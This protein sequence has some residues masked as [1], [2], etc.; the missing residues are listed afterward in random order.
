MPTSLFS[1]M[2]RG[3]NG[4]GTASLEDQRALQLALELSML[5]LEGTPGCPGTGTG[6]GTGTTNDPDPLQTTPAGVFE[7]ARSKKSQNMTECVPVPSS[8]HVAEIVGRQGCKIKALR[9]KTNT[10]IKTPVRGEEPVFV[11]TGRKEDVARAKREILSAAEHFSQIRASRKSSLGA[12]LGAPP[13]PPASVPG[14]VTIQVRVPYRVVGLV[15]GPKGATIKRIQHQTHTY[16]VTPSRDKEP[17]FE[18]T[19]LPESVEAARREI[20]AH[21]A[22]RTGT[23]TTLDDSELLSVL[24]RGGLGSILGCLDP[25]GSNGSNGSSGAFSSS[26]SCSSSSSSSGAPGLNDLVAI[27]GAGMERDEGL[28]ESPSFESQTAS[29]SS[30]WSFPGV[31]LP[32][33][34]SPPAS[35]SP[36]SPTDSL[37]G[38]GRRECVV[39]GD[40]EVTAALVPCG[41]NHFCLDCGNRVCESSD[42]S[43]P[44]CSRPVLQALRIFS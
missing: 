36:T 15:V 25:P 38:G 24:C 16:I 21:I 28:G 13:G 33:R 27:W 22:L 4:G 26:G 44:I 41:H 14:H 10:Y 5:G 34:P 37:L 17:V 12:L 39:C 20:E 43:C 23:G 2:D 40:K 31:P 8:E 6:T 42:P 29:A 7:E 32:S 19:G 1:E 11:V 3:A 18:V 9:A 35:A 30:I